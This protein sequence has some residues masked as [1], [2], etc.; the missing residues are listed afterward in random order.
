M[1]SGGFFVVLCIEARDCE[2]ERV[3]QLLLERGVVAHGSA[4]INAPCSG[5]GSRA[6]EQRLGQAGLAA[7]GLSDER[8]R[9]DSFDGMCHGPASSREQCPATPGDFQSLSW[10]GPRPPPR[11]EKSPVETTRPAWAGL[12]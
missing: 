3:L 2:L 8:N 10:N 4:A 12:R 1:D 6:S 7:P 5:N 9:P 11:P